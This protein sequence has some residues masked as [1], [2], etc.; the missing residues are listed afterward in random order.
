LIV[1]SPPL[2]DTPLIE[3]FGVATL[4]F[5]MSASALAMFEEISY[6]ALSATGYA[7]KGSV[8]TSSR[9]REATASGTARK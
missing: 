9:D 3:I 2:A 8:W 5:V 1:L 4:D 7:P 6:H